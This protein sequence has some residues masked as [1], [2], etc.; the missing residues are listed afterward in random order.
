[1]ADAI[2]ATL[3]D[4]GIRNSINVLT[5]HPVTQVEQVVSIIRIEN[6]MWPTAA[7]AY[8]FTMLFSPSNV[9]RLVEFLT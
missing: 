5:L 3:S 4:W 6:D 7:F 2:M 8:S 1:M 9:I